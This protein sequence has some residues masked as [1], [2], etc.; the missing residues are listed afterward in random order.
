M[1]DIP[2]WGWFALAAVPFGSIAAS[3]VLAFFN[4]TAA[5][6]VIAVGVLFVTPA[7]AVALW[8]WADGEDA[9]DSHSD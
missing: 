9:P 3:L 6:L 4:P 7:V 2:S 5:G 8:V 1:S